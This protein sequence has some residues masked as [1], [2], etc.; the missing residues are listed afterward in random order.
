[1][2]IY[3]YN[4]YPTIITIAT[5]WKRKKREREKEGGKTAE[6]EEVTT[7]VND[8]GTCVEQKSI[9]STQTWRNSERA[10]ERESAE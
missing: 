10:R 7:I 6:R 1:M 8:V 9:Y 2:L 3:T 5:I 4:I